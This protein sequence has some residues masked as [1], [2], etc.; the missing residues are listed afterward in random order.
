MSDF[1]RSV[2]LKSSTQNYDDQTM[3]QVLASMELSTKLH[4]GQSTTA[5][6]TDT[7]N[8]F[9]QDSRIINNAGIAAANTFKETTNRGILSGIGLLSTL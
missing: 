5:R 9:T 6:D 7:T 3:S 2:Q 8:A 1:N 4:K